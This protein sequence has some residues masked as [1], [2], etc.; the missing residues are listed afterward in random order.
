MP[1][2][3]DASS[4]H[5][6]PF[7]TARQKACKDH[8]RGLADSPKQAQEESANKVD[9]KQGPLRALTDQPRESPYGAARWA[10]SCSILVMYSLA[11]PFPGSKRKT[12]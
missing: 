12:V 3:F 4:T 1:N 2:R 7:A 5:Q 6:H 9:S 8:G 11:F 10:F